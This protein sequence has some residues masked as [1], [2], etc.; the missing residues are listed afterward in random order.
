VVIGSIFGGRG[1][2]TLYRMLCRYSI[3]HDAT[4][5]LSLISASRVDIASRC[6]VGHFSFVRNVEHLSL[7]SECRIGT[8]NWI[9]GMLP[10]SRHFAEE[11]D[12]VSALVMHQGSSITS[13]HIVDCTNTVTIGAFSTVAG[14]YSQILTHGIDIGNN[15]QV[16]S[17]V[18]VGKH[19]MIGT[20]AVILKGAHVP[21]RA[22]VG[23]GSVFRGTPDSTGGLW[24]GVPARRVLDLDQSSPYFTRRDGHVS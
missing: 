22:V 9:F 18:T 4:I 15:R 5:G 7:A 17:P 2:A 1:R 20:R 8:F 24:S 21:D 10:S 3:A 14:F 6:R 12:R 19:A 13:R 23:A 16:S 11:T